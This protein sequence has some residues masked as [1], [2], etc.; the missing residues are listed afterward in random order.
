MIR[1]PPRS[2]L[3]PYPTLSRSNSS[4]GSLTLALSEGQTIDL[5][6]ADLSPTLF[7]AGKTFRITAN[8]SDGSITTTDT[9]LVAAPAV[10]GVTP[11]RASPGQ[12]LAVKVAGSNFQ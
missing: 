11:D 5:F 8:F 1:R 6:A 10:A 7:V 12:T 3:F 4:T 2:T 9:T